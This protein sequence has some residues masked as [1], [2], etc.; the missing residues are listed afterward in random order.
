MSLSEMIA[1][2]TPQLVNASQSRRRIA[3][4]FP[5]AANFPDTNVT[6]LENLSVTDIMQLYPSLEVGKARIKLI[7]IV[8]NS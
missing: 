7:E 3:H 8:W 4:S 5:P 1:F 6:A 2:G